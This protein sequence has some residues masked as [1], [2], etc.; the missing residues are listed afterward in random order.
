VGVI[1]ANKVREYI[2]PFLS[3]GKRGFKSKVCL[4]KVM[5][6]ILKRLKTGCQWRE[7]SLKEY[8]DEGEVC[9]QTIYYYFNKWSRDG[10]FKNVW[11][12]LLQSN[13]HLVDLSTAQLDGSHTPGKR[14]G[15]SVGYQG[16][17]SCKTSN[18]LILSD[19][20]GMPIC[21]GE[22]QNGKQNDLFEINKIFGQML[23]ILEEAEVSLE[24]VFLNA[25][26]GFDGKSFKKNVQ[27]K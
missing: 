6:L 8:F 18:S 2:V 12:N 9:W 13:K 11:I 7:L 20:N 19:N 4:T 27:K 23:E 10:S 26:P 16:R 24:A 5:L 25:D 15:Q 22:P 17:K 1:S 3:V 21:I 14:G